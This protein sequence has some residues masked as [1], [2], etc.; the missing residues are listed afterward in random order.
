[1]AVTVVAGGHGRGRVRLAK[2]HGLAVV[3]IPVMRQP[4]LVAFAATRVA[5]GLEVISRRL[6]N[7]VSRVAIRANRA[8]LVAPGQQ[9]AMNA[10]KVGFLDADVAFA[11][12]F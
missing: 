11:A 10:L 5:D 7:L 1:M 3:G 4:V 6:L 9:L 8:A 2:R 12:G